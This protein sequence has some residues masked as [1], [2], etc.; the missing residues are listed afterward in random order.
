MSR[1]L[2]IVFLL[3]FISCEQQYVDGGFTSREVNIKEAKSWFEASLEQ[4]NSLAGNL[5]A[6]KPLWEKAYPFD[7][8]VKKALVIPLE[9]VQNLYPELKLS[10]EAQQEGNGKLL[11]NNDLNALLIYKDSTGKMQEEVLVVIPDK[12]YLEQS[13]ARSKKYPFHG[14]ILIHGWKGQFKSGF[15]FEKGVITRQ[16][17]SSAN[18]RLRDYVPSCVVIDWYS[19]PG[20]IDAPSPQCTFLYTENRC[21]IVWDP[22]NGPSGGFGGYGAWAG[23]GSPGGGPGSGGGGCISNY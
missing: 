21:S 18:A 10:D 6:R 12:A 13:V 5:N 3:L 23:G 20:G 11:S 19:C 8:G 15:I 7:F 1:L 4:S 14:M 22:N 9:Y 2:P 16:V 17:I